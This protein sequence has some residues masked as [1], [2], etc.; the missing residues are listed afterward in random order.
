MKGMIMTML[1]AL[2]LT[3]CV[4]PIDWN[5]RIGVYTYNQAVEDYGPPISLTTLKDGSNVGDWMTQRGTVVTTPGPYVSNPGL[6]P[7]RGFYSTT[8]FPAQF[9]RLEFGVDDRLKT[10]KEYSK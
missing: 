9:L 7:R 6:Y 8:Y 2:M 3:G 1:V 4:T 10:W 5:A